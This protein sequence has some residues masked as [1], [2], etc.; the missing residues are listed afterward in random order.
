MRLP[1]TRSF[2]RT[3]RG[4]L[5]AAG[6][7][8]LLISASVVIPVEAASADPSPTPN[9]A[10]TV[11]PTPAPHRA[12]VSMGKFVASSYA[13]AAS[14]LPSG[15]V[16]ALGRDLDVSPA[17]YLADAAAAAQAVKVVA[18]LK[19]AGVH[20]LGSK[21]DGTALTVNVAS[22]SDSASVE[23]SGA[24]AVVGAPVVPDFSHSDFHS[25]TATNTYGGQGYF[26]QEQSQLGTNDGFRCSIGFNGFSVSASVPE[27][28]TAGHC[29]TTIAPG[30]SPNLITQDAPTNYGGTATVTGTLLGPE[31][32]GQYGGGRDYGIVGSGSSVV[33]QASLYTWGGS[34]GAP[35]ASAA[36]PIVGQTAGMVGAALCKSGSTSGWTC[37]TILSIDQS[38]PVS[39]QNVNSIVATTCLLPGDSG[40]GAVTGQNAVG[41]DSGSDFPT[42]SC[43]NPGGDSYESVFFPM[44]STASGATGLDSVVGQQGANW[45]L[46]AAPVV[47]SP[48]V[49]GAV[50]AS[51]SM[52]GTLFNP[53]TSSTVSLYL[54]GSAT[55]FATASASSGSWSIPLTGLAQ[56]SHSYSVSASFAGNSTAVVTGTFVE[57]VTSIATITSP[58]S[59]ATLYPTSILAGTI[60]SPT[61]S[62]TALLYLDGS[63][64]PYANV[65]ASTGSW[66]IPLRGIALGSHT[67][68]LAAGIGAVPGTFTSGSFTEASVPPTKFAIDSITGGVRSVS[69]AGWAV[70]PD[71][72]S[73]SVSLAI[74]VGGSWTAMT[75]NGVNMDS[76][77]PAGAGTNHGF[78]STVAL[79]PGSYSVCVWANASGGG[80]ATNLGCQTVAVTAAPPTKFAIDSISG[81]VNSV[82][83]AGWAV[84]PD[85]LSSSV[86]IAVN[87]GS[88]WTGLTANG[89]NSDPGQ[90]AGAGTNHGFSGTIAVAPGTY[91]VCVWASLSGG[92]AASIAC[93]TVTVTAAPP[94][95]FAI[96]SITGGAG[97]AS[98]AGWAVWPDQ[99]SSSVNI[100]IQVGS[101]WV[102]LTAN[103][104]NMDG[105]QPAG[106]GTNHG[107]TGSVPLGAG[108]YTVCVWAGLSGGGAA[109][110]GCQ[111]VTVT[112]A[113][114]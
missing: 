62:S 71:Q 84:W 56:G 98:V 92:G 51:A 8:L 29:A 60:T 12:A 113:V 69:V 50:S 104:V 91:S 81:G 105:G 99:P 57:A 39:D 77:Q 59:L 33:P 46:L 109:S 6:A 37:G 48:A 93:Q 86:N 58:A 3:N 90:P 17:Q 76:G 47:T 89:A 85:Q 66:S 19:S 41:I 65:P 100:A 1:F 43:S 24:T 101:T 61:A 34:T 94:T 10:V 22:A 78:T 114:G 11:T 72:L 74:Q 28:V 68:K 18:S 87:I 49:G 13:Y 9:P 112:A 106:A 27:F 36:L 31:V 2:A 26:Y 67:Y 80:A 35:L 111:P 38:I 64:T 103:G 53:I 42:D 16:T 83:V 20:V 102:G 44:V 107:F 54:D 45:K 88:S 25:V 14:R 82:S 7:S 79:A 15:L 96:D 30:T 97:F 75:A 21:I 95:K 52:T 73:A 55:A 32:A 70:W 4:R 108:H 5:V 23:A 63:L 40:G 110:L